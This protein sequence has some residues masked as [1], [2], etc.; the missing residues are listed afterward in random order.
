MRIGLKPLGWS[1]AALLLLLSI[2]TPL[3]AVTVFL[4]ITPFVILYTTLK[5]V[6]FAVY[7]AVIGAAVL[8]LGGP[9]APLLIM[10]M[11]FYMIPA[12]VMGHFYKRRSPVR[13]VL[14]AGFG[15]M[16]AQLLI[17][18]VVFAAVFK[19]DIAAEIAYAVQPSLAVLE[20]SG[21]LEPG[22]AQQTAT[23]LGKAMVKMLP[24]LLIAISFL[25]VII[26]HGVSRFL[27]RKSGIEVP[28]LPE[29]KSWQIPRS[30]IWYY[31]I[32][33][34]LSLV[35]PLEG[36]GFWGIA[37]G[38]LVP[39]LQYVF[40]IQAIGFFFYLA[41]ARKWSKA[42]PVIISVPL[43]LFPQLYLIGLLDAAFPLRR[44]LTKS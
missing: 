8:F 15:V 23:D 22:W 44:Y 6:E 29:A 2:L 27:L 42:V 20:A 25:F 31:L 13:T 19:V 3:S 12:V 34:I 21:S 5:P 36:S 14:V 35:I 16:L 26:T 17:E 9:G 4:L 28:G 39:I 40:I 33:L 32:A 43:V 38:N 11:V 7:A 1:L 30:L 24:M 10:L 18:L 37:V 41:D